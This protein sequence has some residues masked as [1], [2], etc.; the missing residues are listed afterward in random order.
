MSSVIKWYDTV[1]AD[2]MLHEKYRDD[3]ISKHRFVSKIKQSLHTS[4]VSTDMF[5]EW[6]D[7]VNKDYSTK[8]FASL[9]LKY[10]QKYVGPQEGSEGILVDPRCLLDVNQNIAKSMNEIILRDE[11]RSR[12]ESSLEKRLYSMERTIHNLSKLLTVSKILLI[13]NICVFFTNI[14]DNQ[15]TII[16]QFLLFCHKFL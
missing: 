10:L 3:N 14:G 2:I 7:L 1:E 13:T 15:K 16:H 8:N 12:R 5:H 9:P 4:K 6:K 11:N